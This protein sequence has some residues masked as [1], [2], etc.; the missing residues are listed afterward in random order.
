M[1]GDTLPPAVIPPGSTIGILGGGQLGRMLAMAAAKMGYHAHIYAP[2][3]DCPAAEVAKH[4]TT[5]AYD[6]AEALQKF[7]SEVDVITYEFENIPTLALHTIT[8][9]PIRPSLDALEFCQHRLR[10]KE[11][12]H[13]CGIATANFFAVQNRQELEIAIKAIGLPAILK[14]ATMGYD[15]KG[16]WKITGANDVPEIEPG[17]YILEAF[18]PFERELSVIVARGMDGMSACYIPVENIHRNHILHQTIA[19]AVLPEGIAEKAEEMATRIAENIGLVGVLAVEMFLKPDGAL[20]V[21]ELAPR[22]HNSGHWTMDAS[23]TSQFEQLLRA[24]CGLK[25]GS[26]ALLCPS[27]MTNLLGDEIKDWQQYTHSL[28][29]RLH[30]YGKNETKAGRKMGHVTQLQI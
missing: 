6:D 12:L 23:M 1:S 2:E 13:A 19:P 22:P 27:I 30:L 26:T 11:M 25:L 20:L 28:E 3:V 24:I 16:Q 5:A 10:E 18:V 29:C 7:A 17:E 15:G 9:A 21:N 4:T 14:T 8:Q